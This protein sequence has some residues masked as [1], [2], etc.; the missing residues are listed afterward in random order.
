MQGEKF[1]RLLKPKRLIIFIALLTTW[2]PATA[3]AAPGPGTCASDS[4]SRQLD[5]WLG[6]WTV[7]NPGGSGGTSKV[8][9]SLDKCVFVEHWE[10]GK[11]HVTDKNFAYSPDDKAWYGW[12]ADNQGRAHVF[13]DG[14][15]T[16]SKAEFRGPS[17][18][19]NGETVLNRLT[20][21]RMPSNKLEESWEKSSDNG[22]NWTT[23]YR[24]EYVRAN[25]Q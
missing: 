22:A 12:F 21:T 13:T 10:N 19:P 3:L 16:A 4:E 25:S 17:R 5:F 7:A 9:L 18:G 2:L 14:K 11:G 20:V 24:A 15:V 8:Y 6:T 23:S 1:V